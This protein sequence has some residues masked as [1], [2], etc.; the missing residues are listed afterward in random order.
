MTPATPEVYPNWLSV[1]KEDVVGA[2][3]LGPAGLEVGLADDFA[4]SRHDQRVDAGDEDRRAVSSR[5]AGKMAE[6]EHGRDRGDA[7][8]PAQAGDVEERLAHLGGAANGVVHGAHAGDR[9]DVEIAATRGSPHE[10]DDE[11]VEH[12]RHEDGDLRRVEEVAY[13][14]GARDEDGLGKPGVGRRGGLGGLL[15]GADEL[16]PGGSVDGL[17]SDRVSLAGVEALDGGLGLGRVA[18]EILGI[19]QVIRNELRLGEG[20]AGVHGLKAVAGKLEAG[21]RGLRRRRPLRQELGALE[22]LGVGGRAEAR[23][24]SEARVGQSE[25]CQNEGQDNREGQAQRRH[26]SISSTLARGSTTPLPS[27]S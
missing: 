19:G 23:G 7:A 13:G 20:L 24:R 15:L 8:D 22:V 10:D 4:L 17:E 6:D 9:A 21:G 18:E 14:P 1:R 25:R 12:D 27:R 3:G 26:C 16:L 2:K 11:A 5:A